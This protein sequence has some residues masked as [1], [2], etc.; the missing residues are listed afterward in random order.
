LGGAALLLLLGG[1]VA[2]WPAPAAAHDP[3]Q[4]PPVAPVT[5]T[6]TSDGRGTLTLAAEPTGDCAALRPVGVVARRAGQAVTGALTPTG[7]CRFAGQVRVPAAGRWFL[8]AQLRGPDGLVEAWLPVDARPPRR[9]VERRQLY[10]PTGRPDDAGLPTNQLVSG[11]LL[12]AVGILVLAL[13]VRQVRHLPSMPPA[14][15]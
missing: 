14:G 5:L 7:R 10:L 1:S 12:Y 9:L 11:A 8:Y 2:S 3:G 4:G 15:P 13:T 6:G